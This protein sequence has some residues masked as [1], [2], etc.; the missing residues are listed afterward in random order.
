M[1]VHVRADVG[2]GR[3]GI[4]RKKLRALDVQFGHA[5]RLLID[6]KTNIVQFNRA[7]VPD[8]GA[9]IGRRRRSGTQAAERVPP[10]GSRLSRK[11]SAGMTTEGSELRI[12]LG[13][14][15]L[16]ARL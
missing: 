6:E 2:V 3:L 8:A 10:D 13:F 14:R 9:G 11:C 15:L 12:V 7:V 1:A 5:R 4:A 16:K